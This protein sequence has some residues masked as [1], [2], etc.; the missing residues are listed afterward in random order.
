MKTTLLVTILL[1]V[2]PISSLANSEQCSG[3]N[4]QEQ[5]SA[6]YPTADT[7]PENLLR[8]Y[9]YF[10]QP[11][12]TEDT[13]S[14]VYLTDD[15]GKRLEGVFLANKVNLWSPDRKR[16]TLLFDPGRVKTG[17]IAHNTLG[18]ALEAGSTYQ[19]VINSGAIN[20]KTCS[21]VY[22]K[23][24]TVVAPNYEK[25][26]I[27]SWRISQPKE[28]TKQPL[29]IDFSSPIDHTSL[30]YRIRV[31]NGVGKIV[32]GL[33]D[34]GSQEQKW[35]FIPNDNWSEKETYTLFV[36]PILEDIVGNRITGLFDQPS[37]IEDSMSRNK[38]FEVAVELTK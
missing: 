16:L 2:F 32:S 13:L 3:F 36:E 20:Q 26:S 34:I 30:A 6:V 22:T 11:M 19:L 5:V 35:I 21:S 10:N 25:P 37:L 27:N 24:F 28:R 38:A 18:R 4:Q 31:K 15:N 9:I 7:L 17:L 12:K 23:R 8:F 29:T 33:I 14:H 1:L